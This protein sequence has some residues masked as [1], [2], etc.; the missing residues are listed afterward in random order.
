MVN[1]AVVDRPPVVQQNERLHQYI[2]PSRLNTWLTCPL[3][4]KFRYVDNVTEPTT[5]SLFLGKQVHSGL[6]FFYRRRKSGQDAAVAEVMQRMMESWDESASQEGM[7]FQSLADEAALRA[8][9]VRLVETYLDKHGRDEEIPLAVEAPLECPLV[10]PQSGED[11]GISLFGYVDL[12]TEGMEGPVIVDFKTSARSSAPLDVTHEIQ[13]SC[14]AYA[15]RQCFGR[16]ESELQIR[17]LIK[18]KTPKCETHCYPARDD[19]HFRR[20][21][22]A[23]RAY[24]DDLHSGRFVYRPGW[25]CCM[26]DFRETHCRHWQG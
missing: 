26:C 13:L 5:P 21:F 9:C 20:L 14:Y 18:T 19:Q 11:L 3:K 2:S 15:F 10:D 4:L 1:S 16:V 24:L 22:A 7:I 17:S 23:I 25:T 12:I 8:L 6:E